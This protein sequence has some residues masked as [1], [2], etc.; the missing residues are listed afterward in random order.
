MGA[1]AST[2]VPTTASKLKYCRPQDVAAIN[3]SEKV[4]YQGCKIC[5]DPKSELYKTYVR[6]D[7]DCATAQINL[8]RYMGGDEKCPTSGDE[9]AFCA[10]DEK[11]LYEQGNASDCPDV[12]YQL[13]KRTFSQNLRSCKRILATTRRTPP[14]D[15]S[16][17][18]LASMCPADVFMF[19]KCDPVSHKCTYQSQSSKDDPLRAERVAACANSF[20]LC[21]DE[22]YLADKKVWEAF[23][24]DCK[25]K[26]DR[27]NQN[28]FWL[29]VIS[30][31][32]LTNLLIAM[33][34]SLFGAGA[35]S[36]VG[37]GGVAGSAA[38]S[39][40][41]CT[42]KSNWVILVVAF[43]VLLGGGLFLFANHFN[44]FPSED[45]FLQDKEEGENGELIGGIV[46][47][48]LAG[49][50]FMVFIASRFADCLPLT[51]G[52]SERATQVTNTT[53]MPGGS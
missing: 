3:F 34:Y 17:T 10:F 43:V 14:A 46:F 28:D 31:F 15:G 26:W 50:V 41:F 24:A 38:G 1:V 45:D 22:E 37:N 13:R 6:D 9:I 49:L 35:F 25:A 32:I 19:L 2:P 21:K 40:V 52:V 44:W 27:Q 8:E 47:S 53:R 5:S 12:N 36:P 23:N 4:A 48:V 51:S 20:E 39:G 7:Q 30:L 18:P 29:P 16:P 33:V 42:L 11:G